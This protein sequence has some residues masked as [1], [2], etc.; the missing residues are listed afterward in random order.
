M[1]F[2]IKAE[3][4]VDGGICTFENVPSSQL[5]LDGNGEL[6]FHYNDYYTSKVLNICAI[7]Q[8]ELDAKLAYFKEYG[9]ACE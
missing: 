5:S 3:D 6:L 7:D 2:N 4:P 8:E 1:N 9:T